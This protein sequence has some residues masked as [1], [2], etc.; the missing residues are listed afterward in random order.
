MA[1]SQTP[2][3]GKT[4]LVT[5]S[6]KRIG[7][8][9]AYSLADAGV[10]ILVHYRSS[11]NEAQDL[12]RNLGERG[13]Q[14]WPV[15]SDFRKPDEYGS[16]IER[17]VQLAGPFEFLIN[18]ASVFRPSTPEDLSFETF[19]DDI[20]INAWAPFHLSRDFARHTGHGAI[21]NLLDARTEG[22]D[23]DHMG[24]VMGKRLLAEFT[25]VTALEFAPE[26]RVN[27][28]APGLILPPAGKD[29]SYLDTLSESVPLR[30]HGSPTDVAKAVLFLLESDFITGQVIYVNGGQR[31]MEH[32]HGPNT[33]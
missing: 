26:I 13:V 24:Y 23:W 15:R 29:D 1:Q 22:D 17:A 4:A 6:A 30:R 12:C 18:N 5:G 7:R 20:L 16:L 11:G 8:E 10:N 32:E 14:A 28:V 21:V 3:R 9:I 31:L 19:M 2:L 33:H 27:A 25:R